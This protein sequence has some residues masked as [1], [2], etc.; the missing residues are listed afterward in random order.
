MYTL[1]LSKLTAVNAHWADQIALDT[2]AVL[3]SWSCS[4]KNDTMSTER[5]N[6]QDWVEIILQDI[7]LSALEASA[8]IVLLFPLV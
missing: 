8:R 1:I 7:P 3:E 4:A 6:L 2:H 5:N